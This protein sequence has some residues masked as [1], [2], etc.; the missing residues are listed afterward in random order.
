MNKIGILTFHDAANYG[1]F[2]QAY[3]LQTALTNL[4]IDSEIIDYKA[5]FIRNTYSPYKLSGNKVKAIIKIVLFSGDAK[6]RNKIFNDYANR[7]LNLSKTIKDSKE[8]LQ[9]QCSNYHTIICGSDQIWNLNLTKNNDSY[10]LPFTLGDTIKASYAGSFGDMKLSDTSNTTRYLKDFKYVSC[11]EVEATDELNNLYNINS[12]SHIDPTLLLSSSQWDE[13]SVSC[14]HKE[15]YVLI[16][17]VKRDLNLVSEAVS[18]A[19]EKGLKLIQISNIR[20]NKDIHYL[21]NQSPGEFLNLFKNADFIFTNSFHGTVFSII[22][23][24]NF[25]VEKIAQDKSLNKR[26]ISLLN[27]LNIPDHILENGVEKIYD[28]LDWDNIFK[29]IASEKA[30]SLNYLSNICQ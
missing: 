7:Y 2:L 3:A 17:T 30:K 4:R 29:I 21:A 9:M 26:V 16:Y 11:R 14:Q 6:K 1:A 15:P 25:L 18:F 23:K 27:I 5:N 13:L 8:D 28:H 10:Y 12:T 24:K 20:R 19:K 22:Y